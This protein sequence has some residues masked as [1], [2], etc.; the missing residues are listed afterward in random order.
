MGKILTLSELEAFDPQSRERGRERRFFCPVCPDAHAGSDRRGWNR[1]LSVTPESGQWYCHRCR[2][3]G[4]LGEFQSSP[5]RP[6]RDRLRALARRTF[7]LPPL[8]EPAAEQLAPL[9]QML[10]AA[11]V[12]PLAGTPGAGYL[13]GRGLDVDQAHH[14][15]VRYA[16]HWGGRPAV[17]FPLRGE[18]GELLA[19]NGRHLDNGKPKTHTYGPRKQGVFAWPG[20]FAADPLVI[21][22]GPMCVLTLALVGVPAVTTTATDFP[23]WLVRRGAFKRVLVAFDA[24]AAG[25]R[26]ADQLMAALRSLGAQP[27]R[28]RPGPEKDFND[29]LQQH[30]LDALRSL[31]APALGGLEPG[32]LCPPASP[33]DLEGPEARAVAFGA[34][35]EDLLAVLAE[36]PARAAACCAEWEQEWACN[37]DYPEGP[38]EAPRGGDPWGSAG[39]WGRRGTTE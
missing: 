25:D 30:G 12:G 35:G 26:G 9:H 16:A 11:G 34:W 27:E 1:C 14:A 8:P 21:V 2:Q 28:F 38:R 18:G 6:R 37:P 7:A 39:R 32:G 33:V 13:A 5:P 15:G 10:R 24:D 17:L 3:S 19:V 4:V 36:G 22:E 23:A 20:A 29:V 31:V